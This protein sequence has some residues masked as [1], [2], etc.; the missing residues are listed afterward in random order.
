MSERN[1]QGNSDHLI[2]N[3]TNIR[4]QKNQQKQQKYKRVTLDKQPT[5][6]LV[7]N[8]FQQITSQ[9]DKRI[10]KTKQLKE[11]LAKKYN[12]VMASKLAQALQGWFNNFVPNVEFADYVKTLEN[13]FNRDEADLKKFAFKI[14]DV[15]GDGIVSESDLFELIRIC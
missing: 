3:K 12:D 9:N 15:N 4:N 13:I 11:Y 1:S 2:K 14:F 8:V 10:T 6:D 7:K 5:S